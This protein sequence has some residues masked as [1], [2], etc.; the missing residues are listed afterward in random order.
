MRILDLNRTESTC[1]I[2]QNF[3][4]IGQTIAEIWRFFAVSKWRLSAILEMLRACLGHPIRVF[5]GIYR[6]A[7]F[8]IDALVS[9]I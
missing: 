4:A 5:G 7:K 3:V 9:I 8:G 1:I 2:V 6:T